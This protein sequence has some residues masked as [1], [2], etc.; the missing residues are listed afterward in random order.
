MNRKIIPYFVVV[1][2]LFV[3]TIT[4]CTASQKPNVS[5]NNN[6]MPNEPKTTTP[7][8]TADFTLNEIHAFDLDIELINNDKIDMEYKKGLNNKESKIET[9]LNGKKS[10]SQHESASREIE[11]LISKLPGASIANTNK[12]IDETL[13]LLKL[14]RQ[15][16]VDFEME[17]LF[18]S[19]E[20]VTIEFNTR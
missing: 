9:F 1:L 7:D 5:D 16:V 20:K 13:S 18:E 11:D 3:L 12:I 4:G 2:L 6:I 17:F 19:G 8:P 14:K 15:D 10:T